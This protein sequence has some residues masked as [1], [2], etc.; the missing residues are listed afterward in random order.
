MGEGQQAVASSGAVHPRARPCKK[1]QR[2]AAPPAVGLQRLRR[3]P[4]RPSSVQFFAVGALVMTYTP[5]L[6]LNPAFLCGSQ[7]TESG[8]VRRMRACMQAAAA[9][10]AAA[11]QQRPARYE[12]LGKELSACALSHRRAARAF[13]GGGALSAGPLDGHL[14]TAQHGRTKSTQ[15]SFPSGETSKSTLLLTPP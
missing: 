10:A 3:R 12:E 5:M 8:A 14:C 6:G 11:E 9:A 15:M 13:A 2:P 1:C 7:P 4:A